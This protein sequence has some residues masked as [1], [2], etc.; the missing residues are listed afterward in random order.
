MECT[1]IL[2]KGG[3]NDWRELNS[4]SGFKG[5]KSNHDYNTLIFKS[6][7]GVFLKFEEFS[8]CRNKLFV[9]ALN[10]INEAEGKTESALTVELSQGGSVIKF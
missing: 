8:C 2:R 9:V 7:Y 1:H 5:L 4:S 10:L 3:L 6:C